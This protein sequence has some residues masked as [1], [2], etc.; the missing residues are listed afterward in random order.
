MTHI[1][2]LL[3]LVPNYIEYPAHNLIQVS[4]FTDSEIKP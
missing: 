1:S 3:Y 2:H 4:Y